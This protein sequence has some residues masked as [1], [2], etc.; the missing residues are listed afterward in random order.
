VTTGRGRALAL[1][2]GCLN[3]FAAELTE[4][5]AAEEDETCPITFADKLDVGC[6][7]SGRGGNAKL[8]PKT[9]GPGPTSVK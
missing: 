6:A 3:S 8:S 9:E 5:A 4:D 2:E 7:D 1:D